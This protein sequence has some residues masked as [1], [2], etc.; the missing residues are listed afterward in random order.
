MSILIWLAMGF[1]LAT[2]FFKVTSEPGQP[3]NS[4]DAFAFICSVIFWPLLVLIVVGWM[5]GSLAI[6]Y[7]R[8]LQG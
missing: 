2:L 1:A 7:I 8:W 5:I 3:V 4:L 6:K